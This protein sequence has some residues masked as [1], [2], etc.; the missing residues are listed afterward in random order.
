MRNYR[1]KF[2]NTMNQKNWV[3]K[4]E[5]KIQNWLA[6]NDKIQLRLVGDLV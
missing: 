6:I 3:Y 4:F 1:K 5:D 2:L